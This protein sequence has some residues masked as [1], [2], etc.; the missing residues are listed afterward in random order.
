MNANPRFDLGRYLSRF[1]VHSGWIFYPAAALLVG[2]LVYMI[3]R[4]R[5]G[6]RPGTEVR[7]P[8]L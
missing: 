1:A 6:E 3:V 2:Y 8:E 5:R 4:K 7:E